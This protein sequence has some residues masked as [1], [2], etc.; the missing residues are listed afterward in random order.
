MTIRRNPF[1][2]SPTN[3]GLDEIQMQSEGKPD[4]PYAPAIRIEAQTRL[5]MENITRSSTTRSALW[6][7][8][9]AQRSAA[10]Q[11]RKSICEGDRGS[12]GHEIVGLQPVLS[13]DDWIDRE[14]P[15]V[16]DEA[17]EVEGDLRVA[18]LVCFRCEADGAGAASGIDF[19]QHSY[20]D[21]QPRDEQ[22]F[23][24]KSWST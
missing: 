22:L 13:D 7:E 3:A 1:K 8:A 16:V 12:V 19:A 15:H 24:L 5:A 11:Q 20:G 9:D 17:G 2:T 6:G 18:R 10:E 21:A 23:N 4:M 14:R